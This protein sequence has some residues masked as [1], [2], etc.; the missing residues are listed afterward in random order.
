MAD[1][2]KP[3]PIIG[4]LNRDFWDGCKAGEIRLQKCDDCGRFRYPPSPLCRHCM[5]ART[6]SVKAKGSGTVFSYVVYH[7][8]FH[9]GF[10]EEIPYIVALIDLE[11]GVRLASRLKNCPIDAVSIGMKVSAIFERATEELTLPL[12]EPA[13]K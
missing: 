2:G 8:A 5:S 13:K 9:K 4:N 3:L 7:Q 10:E 12:F 1:Y 11:E 6:S